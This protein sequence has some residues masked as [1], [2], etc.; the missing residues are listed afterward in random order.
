MKETFY[1]PH[2][3]HARHDHNL[4]NL[5][6]DHGL[7][8]IGAYWCLVEMLY[9]EGGVLPLKYERISKALHSDVS[10]ITDV[11]SLYDLFK[12]DNDTF[13][14]NSVNRRLEERRI[15]SESAR[16]SVNKRW[17]KNTNVLPTQYEGNTIK[18]I[19][20]KEKKD[21]P[22]AEKPPHIVFVDSF[23]LNYKTLTGH[24]YSVNNTDFILAEKMI[25]K[26][27]LD[28]VKLKAKILLKMCRDKSAWFTKDI[29]SFTIGTLSNRWNEIIEPVKTQEVELL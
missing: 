10:F 8:G 3:Y 5:F 4:N 11:I 13:W 16:T 14:S 12:Y 18:E 9:E 6:L 15:K 29:G 20:G 7:K 23:V 21:K 1:F 17:N 2:D 19:K 26:H 27:T 24:P 22:S 25:K 28:V